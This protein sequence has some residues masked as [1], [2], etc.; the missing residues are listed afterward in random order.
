MAA[1]LLRRAL[2]LRRVLPSPAGPA[3]ASARRF[4]PAFSTT[5][6]TPTTSQQNAATTTIDLS[7]DESR[8]RL[9]NRLVYRSKQ[10]GFLEL[11]L[12]LGSWVEQHVRTMDEPNIRALL[13]VLDLENPDLWKWLTGQEQP[14]EDLNSNPV[15][16]AIKSKVADNLTKHASPETRSTPG[17]PWVRGWDDIKKGK[18]GPKYGNQ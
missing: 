7:S 9:L 13:Q 5:T 15:F 10:R 11:D 6:P 17:Q 8:R 16:A 12:V 2:H 1:T 14:P 3:A 4:L 18:D